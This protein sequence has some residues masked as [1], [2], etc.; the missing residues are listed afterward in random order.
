M[1]LTPQIFSWTIY[2]KLPSEYII[3]FC[4]NAYATTSKKLQICSL[5]SGHGKNWAKQQHAY[6]AV[7]SLNL[8]SFFFYCVGAFVRLCLGRRICAAQNLL[9]PRQCGRL[10]SIFRIRGYTPSKLQLAS[11]REN[12]TKSHL[13]TM[14]F[15]FGEALNSNIFV[16]VVAV[17]ARWSQSV[18]SC[19]EV[20]SCWA[21]FSMLFFF[22]LFFHSV[23]EMYF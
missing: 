18:L 19:A 8:I 21:L 13:Q 4:N 22:S 9:S 15:S 20:I 6:F 3:E 23:N 14:T 11:V 7:V 1:F 17:F 16:D 5:P 10:K 12:L 2:E